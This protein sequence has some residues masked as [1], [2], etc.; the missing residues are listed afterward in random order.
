VPEVAAPGTVEAHDRPA[1][2][3]AVERRSGLT[4]IAVGTSGHPGD[5]TYP[6]RD[7]LGTHVRDRPGYVRSMNEARAVLQRLRRIEVLEGEG[8]PARALLAE[9]H[10]LVKEADAWLAVEGSGT[11]GAEAALECC[12]EALAEPAVAR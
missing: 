7:A 4:E 6:F 3:S 10:A 12:R 2:V 5:E 1:A 11:E 9:V 8:A